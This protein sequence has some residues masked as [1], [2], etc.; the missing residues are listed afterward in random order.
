MSVRRTRVEGQIDRKQRAAL[1][2]LSRTP[3]GADP[4]ERILRDARLRAS[5]EESEKVG[6]P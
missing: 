1:D 3:D 5:A 6:A 4:R 2:E